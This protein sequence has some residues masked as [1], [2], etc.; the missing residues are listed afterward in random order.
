[1]K[2][3]V[4]TLIALSV[5]AVMGAGAVSAEGMSGMYGMSASGQTENRQG[6]AAHYAL[7][8]T[9]EHELF[10]LFKIGVGQRLRLCL[11]MHRFLDILFRDG[12]PSTRSVTTIR[13]FPVRTP[14]SIEKIDFG[15]QC[16]NHCRIFPE[17]LRCIRFPETYETRF[18]FQND[19]IYRLL[20]V[21]PDKSE[22]S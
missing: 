17:T 7:A 15:A 14:E 21:I 16:D 4:A 19:S 8:G 6:A 3:S 18:R 5:S 10:Q 12:K 9:A 13:C 1:M 2:R 22:F 20:W 11:R